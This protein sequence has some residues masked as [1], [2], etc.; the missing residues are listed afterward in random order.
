MSKFNIRLVTFLMS[1][2]LLGLIGFQ[3]FWVSNAIKISK[4]QFAQDVQQSLNAVVA[5]LEANE[6]GTVALRALAMD[7]AEFLQTIEPLKFPKLQTK[8]PSEKL[9]VESPGTFFY[10]ESLTASTQV[11][12]TNGKTLSG[13]VST[14]EVNSFEKALEGKRLQSIDEF[15]RMLLEAN[16]LARV[17]GLMEVRQQVFEVERDKDGTVWVSINLPKV[18]GPAQ[19]RVAGVTVPQEKRPEQRPT[20]YRV[21]EQFGPTERITL[22]DQEKL[23]S[24]ADEKQIQ[25][26]ITKANLK[27]DNLNNAIRNL[28]SGESDITKRLDAR[29]VKSLL[30]D[31]LKQRGIDLPYQFV[32]LSEDSVR[33][34]DV[35][36]DET[37]Q[38]V[39]ASPLKAKLYPNDLISR[40]NFL[41]IAFPSEEWYAVQ[42]IW[43]PLISS[44]IFILIIMVCF[45]YAIKTILRQKKLSE[46]KN[47]FVNNMTHEFKTPIATVSLAVEALQDPEL[48][49]QTTFRDR[50]INIIQEEN[51]R[52]GSQVEKVLQIAALD[53]QDFKLKM[54]TIHVN[55]V[56]EK[57]MQHICLQVEKRN[58]SLT[59][60]LD[61]KR[62]EITADELHL[63]NII[64]NL[65]DNANKYSPE[66]P[67]ISIQTEEI[68]TG[69]FIKIKDKGIGMSKDAQKKIFEKFYRVPTGN[70]HDVKG[71]GLGLTYVKTMVE[72]H[73]GTIEVKSEPGKGSMFKL[74]FPFKK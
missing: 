32:I 55:D 35:S 19:Q 52:L 26:Q 30:D 72:A 11:Q 57:A 64:Y 62:D 41:S 6:A 56:I 4:Q 27:I 2:A 48:S 23:V 68:S 37:M 18:L 58:G 67:E 70:L 31:E 61:A 60:R 34:A 36:D 43:L 29:Q 9:K 45:A 65:L 73:G 39:I 66:T 42:K 13:K 40:S 7:S 17:Q 10:S 38:A 25:D 12:S 5:K 59:S 3:Y 14:G 50:Y 44:L 1:V 53:K 74:F 8:R 15:D 21:V 16:E 47:D 71:F 22:I 49:T 63:T 69:I 46:M 24:E 54:E 33:V 20:S 28:V 51:K